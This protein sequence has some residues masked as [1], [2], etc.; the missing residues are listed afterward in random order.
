MPPLLLELQRHQY[1]L[2]KS[3][4]KSF[5]NNERIVQL[6]NVGFKWEKKFATQQ[7]ICD[8]NSICLQEFKQHD[9]HTEGSKDDHKRS[10]LHSCA[11]KPRPLLCPLKAWKRDYLP[12]ETV[13]KMGKAGSQQVLGK[14]G[15]KFTASMTT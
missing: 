1:I 13:K 14:D 15:E 10:Y 9:G 2:L 12:T 7:T 8:K 6:D 4:K 3:G 11:D 5:I